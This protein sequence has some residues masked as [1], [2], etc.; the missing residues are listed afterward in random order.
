ML[1][2]LALTQFRRSHP[3]FLR[4]LPEIPDAETAAALVSNERSWTPAQ[5]STFLA[6]LQSA[7]PQ[8]RWLQSAEAITA[9][10]R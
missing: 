8:T 9:K 5:N 4:A 2:H 10:K 6:L 7:Q 1:E 3:E